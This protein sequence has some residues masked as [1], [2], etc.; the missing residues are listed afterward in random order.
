MNRRLQDKKR[1]NGRAE[2]TLDIDSLMTESSMKEGEELERAL[3]PEG[4]PQEEMSKEEIHRSYQKLVKRMKKEGI[5]KEDPPKGERSGS[6]V[7]SQRLARA[8]GFVVVAALSV[9]VAA[10]STEANRNYFMKKIRYLSGGEAGVLINNDG[11]NDMPSLDE[12]KALEKIKERM[13]TEL[14]IF[15][16]RPEGFAFTDC[17][18]D[19]YSGTAFLEYSYNENCIT[20]YIA[21]RDTKETS[22]NIDLH[23]KTQETFDIESDRVPV[24]FS[25]VR[26]EHDTAPS[27]EASWEWD[28]V[29]Y[30]LFG[31]MDREEMIKM[32]KSMK[33]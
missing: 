15:Y 16:Y 30:Q 22:K 28:G 25:E 24:T 32:I 5:Y 33:M 18:L 11:E 26:D 20:L 9:C 8:A 19:E 17:V 27:Y 3:F 14:P 21:G 10:M 31:R 12:D 29:Y 4:Y 6:A 1:K 2:E 13:G 7:G 23:G